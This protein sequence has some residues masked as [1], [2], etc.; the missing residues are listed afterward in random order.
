LFKHRFILPYVPILV[1]VISKLVVNNVVL[2]SVDLNFGKFF[3]FIQI[4]MSLYSGFIVFAGEV[5]FTKS[6]VD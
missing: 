4:G 5:Y 2:K 1:A 6:I 3:T